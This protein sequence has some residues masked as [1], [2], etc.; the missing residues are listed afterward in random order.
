LP[1]AWA[2]GVCTRGV[3]RWIG[4]EF[5]TVLSE[6]CS[7]LQRELLRGQLA[8]ALVRPPADFLEVLAAELE[9]FAEGRGSASSKRCD[10]M[11]GKA[12]RLAYLVPACRPFVLALY[13]AMTAGREVNREK[14]YSTNLPV[15]RFAAGARWLLRLIRPDG[16]M[17]VEFPLEHLV[18]AAASPVS[19]DTATV[20]TF[21]AS[22]WGAGAVK[23]V[24]GVPAEYFE[25]V[26]DTFDLTALKAEVGA[27]R[28][29]TLFEYLAVLF[30]LLAW[31]AEHREDGLA[32]LGDN[33]AAL[34][35]A[36]TLKGHRSMLNISKEI[37]WRRL[38]AG[39][40]YA[41]GHLAAEDNV[42]SDALSRTSAPAGSD[43][44]DF[45]EE[46]RGV[47]RR[48]P[49]LPVDACNWG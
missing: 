39:W 15:S 9:Y 17:R 32:I 45:P 22:L 11:V 16:Q 29:Q 37:A 12:G 13:A 48:A 24:R 28:C 42:L 34:Q 35:C 25:I 14:G 20:I 30:V 6:T 10:A 36:V 46:L 33:V 40:F 1:L 38:R 43:Q 19:F 31:G 3:H 26:W 49:R 44:K 47:P 4:A 7:R 2:K 18:A 41:V 23:Y 8:G 5:D 21:D 27:P